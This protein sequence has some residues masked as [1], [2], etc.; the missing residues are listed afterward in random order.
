MTNL[1]QFLLC[2]AQM[3]IQ[4]SFS[5]NLQQG[6]IPK[7]TELTIVG[8]P[9]DAA[10]WHGGE[11]KARAASTSVLVGTHCTPIHAQNHVGS[12]HIVASERNNIQ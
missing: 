1:F 2:P 10:S 7:T 5:S 3:I 6:S 4:T 11:S 9:G 8:L 12:Y